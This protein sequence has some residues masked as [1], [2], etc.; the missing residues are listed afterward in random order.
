M[1]IQEIGKIGMGEER[2]PVL[3]FD[4]TID[5][6]QVFKKMAIQKT[7][8]C[9]SSEAHIRNKAKDKKSFNA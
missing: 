6:K 9:G 3:H 1:R 5:T 4:Q 8:I 2:E 7:H